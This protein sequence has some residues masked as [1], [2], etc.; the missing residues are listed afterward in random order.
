[1]Q[2]SSEE[3]KGKRRVIETASLLE[4]FPSFYVPVL[5]EY[6]QKRRRA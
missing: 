1:M 4:E 5:Q 6:P 2:R 3:E